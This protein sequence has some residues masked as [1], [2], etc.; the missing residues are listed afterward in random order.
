MKARHLSPLLVLL[1]AACAQHTSKDSAP[2]AEACVP[3]NRDQIAALFDRWNKALTDEDMDAVL[4]RYAEG[5]V[6]LPTLKNGPRISRDEK[7]DYFKTFLTHRP[8][9]TIDW[10]WI[11]IDCRT[12]VDTGLYSFKYRADGK[13]VRARYTYSYRFDGRDW[14]ITSHHSSARPEG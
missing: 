8:V 9:G 3:V 6:L 5:S 13:T 11:D 14:F 12:A 1:L 2:A 4:D 10:R 7:K